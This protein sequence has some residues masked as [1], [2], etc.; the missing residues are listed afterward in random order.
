MKGTF[1]SSVN[2]S[3]RRWR[4][5][6]ARRSWFCCLEAA[7]RCSRELTWRVRWPRVLRARAP[8]RPRSRE[9]FLLSWAH[10]SQRPFFLRSRS[11]IGMTPSQSLAL[12]FP[13]SPP[14]V[15]PWTKMGT[16]GRSRRI[17]PRMD[18]VPVCPAQFPDRYPRRPTRLAPRSPQ[19]PILQPLP[20]PASSPIDR[21]V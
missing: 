2:P 21:V 9:A 15:D 8:G 4:C 16:G 17:P 12:Q 3:S 7:S 14:L 18:Q 20:F 1:S 13:Q 6:C 19:I 10:A 11:P 5:S